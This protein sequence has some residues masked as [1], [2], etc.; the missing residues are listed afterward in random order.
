MQSHQQI[1][2]RLHQSGSASEEEIRALED[3]LAA[4][5]LEHTQH[6][7]MAHAS[8]KY[9][10]EMKEKCAYEWNEIQKLENMTRSQAQDEELVKLKHSF[11]LVLSADYQMNKLLPYWGR[12][13]QPGSTNYMYLQKLSYDVFGIVDHRDDHG[14]VFCLVN[15]L[16]P[17]LLTT[18]FHT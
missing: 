9:Y 5:R 17:R 12:S 3:K 15:L 14:R 1:L 4:Y 2:N 7:E 8:L 18:Y 11:T 10:K 16:G 13:P 6:K